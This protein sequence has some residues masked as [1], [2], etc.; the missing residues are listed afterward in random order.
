M[1]LINSNFP[2]ILKIYIKKTNN[3]GLRRDKI[4]PFLQD[5]LVEIKIRFTS[6]KILFI[7]IV[8]YLVYR[9]L[10]LPVKRFQKMF[11]TLSKTS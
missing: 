7:R 10:K 2:A 11:R 9:V 3:C 4:V 6:S 1:T 5:D 8:S